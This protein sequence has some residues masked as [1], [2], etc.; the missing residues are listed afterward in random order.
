MVLLAAFQVLLANYTGQTDIA[1]GTPVANRDHPDVQDVGCFVNVVVVRTD[2]ADRPSFTQVVERVRD[3]VLQARDHQTCRSTSCWTPLRPERLAR[4][5]LFQVLFSH[6]VDFDPPESDERLAFKAFAV[7]IEA[8]QFELSLY[9]DETRH[10]VTARLAYR[11]DLFDAA[12]IERLRDS[13][14]LLLN[15][16]TRDPEQS[17]EGLSVVTA[18][19]RSLLDSWNDTVTDYAAA[20]TLTALLERQ[21]AST[22]DAIALESADAVLSFAALDREATRL[23]GL[24]QARGVDATRRSGCASTG[25]PRW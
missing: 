12:T 17:I 11:S 1:V 9:V 3:H 7:D 2:L 10:G 6:I 16:V 22:P 21:A 5:P 24:L 15:S 8:S 18:A 14:L 25:P 20:P 23:A 4:H 19:E 13:Y